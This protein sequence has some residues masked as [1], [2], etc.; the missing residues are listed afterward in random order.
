GAEAGHRAQQTEASGK[1]WLG[2]DQLGQ[3]LVEQG[4][5][6]LYPGEPPLSDALQQGVFEMAGL[7]LHRNMLVA[8]LA[9]HRDGLGEPFEGRIALNHSRRHDRDIVGDQARIAIA[10]GAIAAIGPEPSGGYERGIVRILLAAGWCPGACSGM[11]DMAGAPSSP[12][13]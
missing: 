9:S 5:V 8:E 1:V 4:D 13:V 12:A 6:G 10:Q 2:C 3:T 7:A 11:E